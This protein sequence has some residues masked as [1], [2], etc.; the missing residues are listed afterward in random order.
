MDEI[1]YTFKLKIKPS[2][3]DAAG[4]WRLS[5]IFG[6]MQDA[7][8]QHANMLG[9]GFDIMRRHNAAW[10]V[11]RTR[12]SIA[13]YP[14]E[15][16]EIT[17]KTWP[18]KMTYSI[19]PRYFVMEDASGEQIGC[20][21]AMWVVMD[22]ASRTMLKTAPEWL[23]V[24]ENLT[25]TPPVKAPMAVRKPDG[26]GS[27]KEYKVAYRDLDVNR[28]V[29]NAKYVDMLCDMYDLSWHDSHRITDVQVQ[30]S[31]EI[32]PGTLLQ[33][34]RIENGQKIYLAGRDNEQL[35]FAIMAQA[36]QEER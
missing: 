23:N 13:R 10:V 19:Y 11:A 9:V 29:N 5:N 31:K 24:A 22:L 18:G 4:K 34:E 26:Q 36:E 32:A 6:V 14:K 33:L 35:F 7:A 25:R 12:L 1:L 21:C 28:H 20:A 17:V 15:G 30:Y 3:M 16:E 2:D 8:E 27:I